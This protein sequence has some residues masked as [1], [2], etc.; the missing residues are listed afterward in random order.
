MLTFKQCLMR[1]LKY[2]LVE[3]YYSHD[4]EFLP[5]KEGI[6]QPEVCSEHGY[7]RECESST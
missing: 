1:L 4:L 5:A 3:F 2:I 6:Q 7:Q